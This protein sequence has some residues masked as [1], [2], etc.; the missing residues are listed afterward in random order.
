MGKN[1]I[2]RRKEKFIKKAMEIHRGEGL[3]YSQVEYINNR[4]PV[5]IIDPEY[6]EFWQTPSNHLRGQRHPKRKGYCIS[7]IR[8]SKQEDVI[9][10]FNDVHKGEGLDYSQ[11]E[12]VNMHTKVK[13]IDPEYGEFWQEP[14]AH[15]RGS[16]HPKRAQERIAQLN[17]SN[18]NDFIEKA[19]K[20]HF[21]S[22]Y[23]Y[24]HVNYVTNKTKIEIIC[25]KHGAFQSLPA[26]IL[27]GKGC[28]LCGFNISKCENEISNYIKDLLG[29]EKEVIQGDNSL[30]GN[31]EIDIYIPSHNLAIEYDGLRWHSEMYDKDSRY[32][33]SKTEGC[34]KKGV[35][36]IHIFEDEYIDNKE[37][38]LSK[39]RHILGKDGDL[40]KICGRKCS[41]LA[42]GN[43]EAEE[44][45]NKYHIQRFVASSLYL[46]AYFNSELIAVMTFKKLYKNSNDW[47]LNRFASNY[48]YICQGVGGKLF[49]FF[50]K[51]Y[52]PKYVRSFLDKRWC[53]NRRYNIYTLLGFT[54][55]GDTSPDYSYYDSHTTKRYH[56]FGF[57]K[58]ILHKKYGLPLT[59]T[60]SEMIEQLGFYKIWDCGLIRYE[61]KSA[62]E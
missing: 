60:E 6:G 50:K 35:N 5:K 49:S 1:N 29:N 59:M 11:V 2:E 45:L 44:F 19:R 39:L 21:D 9:K 4:T 52:N 33:L 42:I 26:N 56:K 41:I 54:D 46:G 15:L 47:E 32:H 3:D 38:I 53:H 34:A 27:S 10:R 24:S 37:L 12:Y 43:K 23:D 61:W 57:R 51:N 55:A 31:K 14:S 40:P 48:N 28:P 58:H 16:V 36:L 20:I 25:K 22:D 30:L 62:K 18:T 8:R 17:R 7:I 13:I